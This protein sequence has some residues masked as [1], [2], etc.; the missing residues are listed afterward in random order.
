LGDLS[1]LAKVKNAHTIW[2]ETG[3]LAYSVGIPLL[4]NYHKHIQTL[5]DDDLTTIIF[6]IDLRYLGIPQRRPRNHIIHIRKNLNEE[7][8]PKIP[9]MKWPINRPISTWLQE[10]VKENKLSNPILP[11]KKI[12]ST[13]VKW[14]KKCDEEMTFRSMVPKVVANQDHY[15]LSV[16]TGRPFIWKEENRFFDLLEYAALMTYP[17]DKILS[18]NKSLSKVKKGQKF[19]SKSVAPYITKWVFDNIIEQ[20]LNNKVGNFAKENRKYIEVDE[21]IWKIDLTIPNKLDRLARKGQL[22]FSKR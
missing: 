2:W 4:I 16:L 22:S 1:K 21:N 19:L 14:A 7:Q 3:P 9:K 5:L 15:T 13:P 18:L 20:L 17:L 8:L 12:N 10:K 6:R 11:N